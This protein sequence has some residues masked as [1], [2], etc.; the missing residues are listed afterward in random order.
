MN[1]YLKETLAQGFK[2][3]L[4]KHSKILSLHI[5][6]LLRGVKSLDLIEYPWKV[7]LVMLL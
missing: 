7:V 4:R 3:T 5:P 1:R 6:Q 2:S